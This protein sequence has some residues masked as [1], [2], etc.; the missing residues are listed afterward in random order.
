MVCLSPVLRRLLSQGGG[1]IFLARP[2]GVTNKHHMLAG[3][4]ASNIFSIRR[5]IAWDVVTWRAHCRITVWKKMKLSDFHLL[6]RTPCISAPSIPTNRRPTFP[7][8][9][10]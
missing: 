3:P 4:Q 9:A 8:G 6:S 2:E 7:L 5:L 1:Q 10:S